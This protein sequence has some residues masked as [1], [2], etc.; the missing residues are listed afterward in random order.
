MKKFFRNMPLNY[1]MTAIL[2]LAIL[3]PFLVISAVVFKSVYLNTMESEQKFYSRNL[4][5]AAEHLDGMLKDYE[6]AL[7][8]IYDSEE[9]FNML[10]EADKITADNVNVDSSVNMLLEDIRSLRE[11]TAGVSFI[12]PDGSRLS[13]TSG[14]GNFEEIARDD[15]YQMPEIM[16]MMTSEKTPV[17]WEAGIQKNQPESKDAAFFSGKKV[18]RN[19]YDKNKLAG[20]AVIHVSALAIDNIQ[21]LKSCGSEGTL[22]V[23]DTHG[24]LVWHAGQE[25]VLMEM[26]E[27]STFSHE[28]LVCDKM[29]EYGPCYFICKDSPY[30]GWRF[31]SIIPKSEIDRQANTFRSFFIIV[32]ILILFFFLLCT[33]LI[34]KNIVYPIK[35][36]IVAMDKVDN[37]GKIN[38]PLQVGQ[39]DEIGCLYHT[40]NRLN[41]RI[42]MLVLKLKEAM[43]QDKEKEIKLLHSQLN[44]HFIYNTLESIRWTAYDKNVPEISKV[45]V[46]LSEILK[47]TI[48]FSDEYV[49]FG[50]EIKM[51]RN[52]IDIWRFRFEDKFT[53]NYEIDNR[54]LTFRT[55][56]FT[57]QPFVEN[58]LVHGF[59]GSKAKGVITVR[60]YSCKD[61]IFAEIEDN[62]CGMDKEQAGGIGEI[63]SEGIGICNVDKA[64][65][66]RFGETYGVQILSAAGRGT[67][68]I[69]RIPKSENIGGAYDK[70]SGY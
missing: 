54:L 8:A 27:K 51:L 12:F 65:R 17:V 23:L 45:V 20:T 66:L 39:E 3:V 35:R 63:Y 30:S 37:L 50:D 38:V 4:E 60:L 56:K 49:T 41:E 62:G 11:F 67:K 40:Y 7:N 9:F 19:I 46:S 29:Y 6:E 18:I 14:Y 16:A 15:R 48:K 31:V 47:Y 1:K 36:L 55:I 57:F 70:N 34:R 33:L 13:A 58:A 5:N 59:K 52:Y 53:V 69:L 2:I 24:Q 22:A 64:L 32:I 21:S 28:A 44:P 26:L 42:D 43:L 25:N 61:D 10:G 68:V